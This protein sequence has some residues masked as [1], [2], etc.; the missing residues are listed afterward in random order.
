[1]A[2]APTKATQ[3]KEL[4]QRMKDVRSSMEQLD[5]ELQSLLKQ[6]TKTLKDLTTLEKTMLKSMEED[7]Q[8]KIVKAKAKAV[9]RSK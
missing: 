8:E 3:K 2:K 4:A 9:K 6:Q 5:K 1:M 7:T